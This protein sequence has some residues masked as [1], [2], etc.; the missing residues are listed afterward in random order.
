MWEGVKMIVGSITTLKTTVFLFHDPWKVGST[1]SIAK[2]DSIALVLRG[3]T[4]VTR[5]FD[6]HTETYVLVLC[7]NCVGWVH[8]MFVTQLEEP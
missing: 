5:Y 3:H 6:G 7:C 1:K 2:K 4:K 8:A